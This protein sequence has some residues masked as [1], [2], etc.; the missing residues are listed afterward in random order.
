MTVGVSHRVGTKDLVVGTKVEWER[1]VAQINEKDGL[2]QKHLMEGVVQV[3][4]GEEEAVEEVEI[5]LAEEDHLLEARWEFQKILGAKLWRSGAVKMGL[6]EQRQSGTKAVKMVLGVVLEDLHGI[7][8][9]V[10]LLG[11]SKLM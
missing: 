8:K 4:E 2:G 10:D 5:K 1:K 9:A 7:N 11:L 6:A 3:G